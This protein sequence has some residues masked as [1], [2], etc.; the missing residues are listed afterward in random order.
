M[1]TLHPV[2]NDVHSTH[3][4]LQIV[5]NMDSND[6]NQNHEIG[7]VMFQHLLLT[8]WYRKFL[9]LDRSLV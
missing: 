2:T 5:Y 7:I 6:H 8:A 4:P 3:L 1:H 9:K